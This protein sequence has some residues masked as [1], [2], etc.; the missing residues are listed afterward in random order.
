MK[1]GS[2]P[3]F[4]FTMLDEGG[5]RSHSHGLKREVLCAQ[6]QS[7]GMPIIFRAASWDDYETAFLDGLS[8]IRAANVS[9]GVFGDIDLDDHR[10]WVERVCGSMG[11]AA[12]EPLWKGRRRDLLREFMAS[13]FQA[14]IVA[15]KDGVISPDYLGR[16]LDMRVVQEFE[17]LGI[18]PSGEAGEYH[19]VVTD[20]PLFREPVAICPVARTLKDGYWFLTV[21]VSPQHS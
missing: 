20:G 2:T 10:R 12:E 13:G 11:M 7:L 21:N 5:E 15:V 6:A 19:T 1:K 16:V 8:E 14:T 18:D 17:Y 4:L 9:A 3:T